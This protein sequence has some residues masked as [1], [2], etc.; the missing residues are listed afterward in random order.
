MTRGESIGH[1]DL[2]NFRLAI[3]QEILGD[4]QLPSIR[5]GCIGLDLAVR[6]DHISGGATVETLRDHV[7]LLL[8]IRPEPV[9]DRPLW[10]VGTARD[11]QFS[12]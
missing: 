1:A 9:R 5:E 8:P 12:G 3:R 7:G 2:F 6:R 10:A 11:D 4:L